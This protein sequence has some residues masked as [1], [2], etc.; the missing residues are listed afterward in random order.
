MA[1]G[2]KPEWAG[3]PPRRCDNCGARYRPKQPLRPDKKYGFCKPECKKQFHKHGAAYIKLKDVVEKLI[4]ARLK[5]LAKTLREIV[6]EEI[7]A[8]RLTPYPP[9]PRCDWCHGGGIV[10]EH[11]T[12]KEMPCQCLGLKVQRVLQSQAEGRKQNGRNVHSTNG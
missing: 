10:V 11:G 5:E 4:S 9:N 12:G 8:P 6:R 3:L 1:A 2:V 7:A